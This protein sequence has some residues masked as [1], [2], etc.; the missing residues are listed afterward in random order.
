MKFLRGLLLAAVLILGASQVDATSK[1]N[2]KHE[3]AA[4]ATFVLYG[5]SDAQHIPHHALCTAFIYKR[6]TDG[7]FLLTAGHCFVNAGAPVDVT[8]VVAEGQISEEPVLQP[9]EVLNYVDDGKTDVAELHLK[10]TKVYP[11]LEL[12]T[13]PTQIDDP[14]FYVGYPEMISQ[15]VYTGRV[16]SNPIGVSG[17][18]DCEGICKGRFL[19]QIGG[20][21]GASGAPVISELTGRVV[22]VLEGHVF[23]NGVLVVPAP[24]IEG[25]Y[26]LVGHSKKVEKTE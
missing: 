12:E 21:H 25:Y 15:V 5:R 3:M 10:T 8:Y 23:E 20:G 17:G 16:S 7:Y 11:V 2:K 14:V 26:T 9:V 18:E 13:K 1:P 6:A 22:G 19:I 4:K 24:T